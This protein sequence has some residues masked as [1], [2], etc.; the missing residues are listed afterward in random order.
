[1]K[2]VK[3]NYSNEESTIKEE[4]K[5][6]FDFSASGTIEVI[7]GNDKITIPGKLV[8]EFISEYLRDRKIDSISFI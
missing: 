7:R 1:M 5:I 4:I 2:S 8:I 3:G 6:N